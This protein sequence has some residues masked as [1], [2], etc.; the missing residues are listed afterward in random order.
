MEKTC[1]NVLNGT[2]AKDDTS[3]EEG[4]KEAILDTDVEEKGTC[5]VVVYN[6][7]LNVETA[8]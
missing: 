5:S 6:A 3:N 7:L 1:I 2:D 4:V 8:S